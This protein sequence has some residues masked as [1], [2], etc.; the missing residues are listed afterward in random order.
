MLIDVPL[1]VQ[2]KQ[3]DYVPVNEVSIRG[4]KPT[5][6]GN[7][8]QIRKVVDVLSHAH[9]PLICVA[10]VRFSAMANRLSVNSPISSIF[11]SYQR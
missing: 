7:N 8:L 10:A 4:Y 9:K 2:Q 5:V 3:I 11:R 6:K 1:D